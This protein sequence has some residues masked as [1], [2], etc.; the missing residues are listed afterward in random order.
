MG[1]FSPWFGLT[2]LNRGNDF[3]KYTVKP[4]KKRR[5]GHLFFPCNQIDLITR[6][7]KSVTRDLV[8]AFPIAR[9]L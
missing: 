4:A 1:L 9:F 8:T 5:N 7:H 3:K 6:F 2:L